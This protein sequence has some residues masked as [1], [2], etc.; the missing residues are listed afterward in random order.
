MVCFFWDV[1]ET[2]PQVCRGGVA[3][4]GGPLRA[5]PGVALRPLAAAEAAEPTAE[6]GDPGGGAAGG[7]PAGGRAADVALC[8]GRTAMRP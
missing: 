7:L 1:S 5:A 8:G 3:G 6:S 2:G 4:A